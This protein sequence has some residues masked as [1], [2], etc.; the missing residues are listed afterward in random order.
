M[1][2]FICREPALTRMNDQGLA[3]LYGNVISYIGKFDRGLNWMNLRL[4]MLMSNIDIDYA[5]VNINID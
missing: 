3:N 2:L 4:M 5:L 1:Y